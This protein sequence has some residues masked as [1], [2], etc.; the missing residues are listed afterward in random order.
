MLHSIAHI[1]LNAL[2]LAWDTII[3]FT[4]QGMPQK[5][6]DDWI[7][8]AKDEASHYL[9]ICNRLK[10]YDAEYGILPAHESLWDVALSTKTNLLKRLAIVPMVF[11]A[12][13][14]DVTPEIIQKLKN[15]K[16]NK[17]AECL[18]MI[19]N[20][21]IGHVKIGE[22]WFRSICEKTGKNPVLTWKS[23]VN[24]NFP[25]ILKPKFNH[26]ARKL[27]GMENYIKIR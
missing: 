20:E 8:V 14:L 5:F 4:D 21:E 12:R 23:L 15:A 11:E 9:M 18:E 7:Q 24:Q 1:E 25:N 16:C 3:R 10:D 17:T 19:L 22:R 2:D 26:H 6:F 27:A 13:G